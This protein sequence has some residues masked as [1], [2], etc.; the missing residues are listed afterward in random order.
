MNIIVARDD[1]GGIGKD[2]SIPWN[3]PEDL[4]NFQ[5]LT[6]GSGNNCMIMGRKTWDSLPVRPLPNRTHIVLSRTLTTLDG[7]I[8]VRSLKEA[9][10]AAEE[11]E[12]CWVIGGS[13]IYEQMIR[14]YPVSKVWLTQIPG[15]Y[16]CDSHFRLLG[17]W[18]VLS[19]QHLSEQVE[20]VE[21]APMSS[22]DYR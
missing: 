8:L 17:D 15:C 4:R 10:S 7:A 22:E 6:T 19:S 11:F 18:K 1:S 2:G 12:T 21:M 13:S 3:F 20:V 9:M 14:E 5:K 16:D